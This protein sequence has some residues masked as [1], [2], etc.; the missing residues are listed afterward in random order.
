MTKVVLHEERVSELEA[1]ITAERARD[2]AEDL[3]FSPEGWER[4]RLSFTSTYAADLV[5]ITD[6]HCFPAPAPSERSF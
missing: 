6:P 4:R 5:L 2:I 1:E 3:G